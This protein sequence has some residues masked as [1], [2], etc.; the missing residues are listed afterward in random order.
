MTRQALLRLTPFVILA[1]NAEE[2]LMMRRFLPLD[3]AR[4]PAPLRDVAPD[5]S[6]PQFLAVLVIFTTIPFLV[7]A[8]GDLERR[9]GAGTYLLV[10]LAGVMLLNV[11]AHV[12]TASVRGGYT[13]GLVTALAL[14][15]P[16]FGRLLFRAVREEWIGRGA[17]YTVPAVVLLVHGPLLGAMAL[18]GWFSGR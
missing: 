11:A 1:H 4:F 17:L 18:A 2:A 9:G 14:N 7:I 5:V 16:F 3:R 15:L 10:A 12:A 6:Y 8:L 13:P